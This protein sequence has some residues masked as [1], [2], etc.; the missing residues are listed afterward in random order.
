MKG[1]RLTKIVKE[2][3]YEGVSGKV[4]AKNVSRDNYSQNS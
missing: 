1:L 2:I 3:K 4:E